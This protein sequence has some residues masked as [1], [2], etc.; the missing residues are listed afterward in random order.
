MKELDYSD[1]K[2]KKPQWIGTQKC[3]FSIEMKLW[4]ITIS[5]TWSQ[6]GGWGWEL[7]VRGEAFFPYP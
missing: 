4:R 3:K 5:E 7:F 2:K 6:I 1:D